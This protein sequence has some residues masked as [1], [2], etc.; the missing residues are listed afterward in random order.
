MKGLNAIWRWFYRQTLR[1][2]LILVPIVVTVM[3]IVWLARSIEQMLAPLV[4]LVLPPDIYFPGFA[5][6]LFL[7]AAF[8]LGIVTRN[9]LM[10]KLGDAAEALLTQLPVVGKIY[11]I[12]RQLMDLLSGRNR[13]AE[14]GQVVTF[15][16]PGASAAVFGIVLR[17]GDRQPCEWL[18]EECDLVYAPMSYQVGGYSLIMPR[19]QLQPVAMSP[20][21][22]LQLIVMGGLGSTPSAVPQPSEPP[23]TAVTENS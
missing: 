22:A 1:G 14:S 2:L 4:L 10:R 20:G 17:R 15:Q 23:V 19:A 5:L 7:A 16:V 9:V 8:V 3:F 18:P 12:V 13:E 11:P 21:E 6:L